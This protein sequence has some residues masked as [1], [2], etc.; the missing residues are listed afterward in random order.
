MRWTLKDA[1][2]ETAVSDAS[3][4][5]LSMNP[6]ATSRIAYH[7]INQ[8]PLILPARSYILP[9]VFHMSWPNCIMHNNPRPV[10]S[11][12][13]ET[14]SEN[15]STSNARSESSIPTEQCSL[16]NNTATWH[17]CLRTNAVEQ[18]SGRSRILRMIGSTLPSKHA[19]LG[20]RLC[21][22]QPHAVHF[23]FSG[24]SHASAA[25]C[26]REEDSDVICVIAWRVRLSGLMLIEW[27]TPS[28]SRKRY[29]A[30]VVLMMVADS[31]CCCSRHGI[32][33]LGRRIAADKLVVSVL[34]ATGQAL[35]AS[36]QGNV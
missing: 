15:C 31:L 36:G 1:R 33:F 23:C 16:N 5:N 26:S 11:G 9:C 27:I 8:R 30:L 12:F 28:P 6:W 17:G 14:D 2:K 3:D 7:G 10:G 22:P 29:L 24:V 4:Q 13:C 35:E 18:I 25:D 19:L 20:K 21:S 32:L 34:H